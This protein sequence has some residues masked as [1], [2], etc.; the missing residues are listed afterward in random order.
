VAFFFQ[1][2]YW[3]AKETD[4]TPAVAGMEVQDLGCPTTIGRSI[5]T[6]TKTGDQ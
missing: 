6:E 1:R 4:T 5:Q 3:P 2:R